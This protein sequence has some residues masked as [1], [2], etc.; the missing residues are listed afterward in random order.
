MKSELLLMMIEEVGV[1]VVEE[2]TNSEIAKKQPLIS[3]HTSSSISII[4]LL[5]YLFS[6]KKGKCFRL[7]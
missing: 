5:I 4:F 1:K 2:V 6:T 7:C 3:E